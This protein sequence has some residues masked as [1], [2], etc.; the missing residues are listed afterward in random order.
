MKRVMPPHGDPRPFARIYLAES[1]REGG[2]HV[3][4]EADAKE[5]AA[6]AAELGLPSI[7]SLKGDFTVA[8]RGRTAVKV[9][10]EVTASVSQT[11][12]ASLEPFDAQIQEQV[13][14]A[15][16]P[17]PDARDAERKLA[18]AAKLAGADGL[19]LSQT[20]DAPEPIIDGLID[21]GALA[22]EFL[23]LGL[24]PYPRKPGAAFIEP[25]PEPAS[26]ATSPFA[27]LGALRKPGK[28]GGAR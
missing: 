9:T 2:D 27:I 26:A 13:D 23:A 8:K 7:H 24:D 5:R 18:N 11:C 28:G 14:C 4:V 17:E 10:G 25:A 1:V 15:F 12:V 21:L 3:S 22:A 16:A 19:V 20:P 6:L